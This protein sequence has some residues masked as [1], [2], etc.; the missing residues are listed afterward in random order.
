MGPFFRGL[1]GHGQT[2]AAGSTSDE[3]VAVFDWDIDGLGTDDEE[4]EKEE[5]E[6]KEDDDESKK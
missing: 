4:E 3:H 6:R 5:R 2:D 1:A